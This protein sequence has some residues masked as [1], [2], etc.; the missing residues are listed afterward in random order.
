[1][2]NKTL[3][4][5]INDISIFEEEVLLKE[6]CKKKSQSFNDEKFN[7]QLYEQMSFAAK[8]LNSFSRSIEKKLQDLDLDDLIVLVQQ[9]SEN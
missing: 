3:E 1:M 7:K 2:K 8:K 5:F 4:S 6:W 9:N